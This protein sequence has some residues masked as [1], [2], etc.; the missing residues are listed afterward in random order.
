MKG[1]ERLNGR[2]LG[3]DTL[4]QNKSNRRYGYGIADRNCFGENIEF[5]QVNYTEVEKA[6]RNAI[7]KNRAPVLLSS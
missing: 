7:H 6:G 2:G 5:V 4:D 3:T 1:D